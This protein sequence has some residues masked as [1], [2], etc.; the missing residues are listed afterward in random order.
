MNNQPNPAAESS[1]SQTQIPP[2]TIA[3]CCAQCAMIRDHADAYFHGAMYNPYHITLACG[4]A[5]DCHINR[6]VYGYNIFPMGESARRFSGPFAVPVEHVVAF[7]TLPQSLD[8]QQMFTYIPDTPVN[9][10]AQLIPNLRRMNLS[11]R[12]SFDL[13]LIPMKSVAM[14]NVA[15]RKLSQVTNGQLPQTIET[16]QRALEEVEVVAGPLTRQYAGFLLAARQGVDISN[17]PVY[18]ATLPLSQWQ[19]KQLFDAYYWAVLAP[20]SSRR[21]ELIRVV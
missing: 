7:H 18:A 12:D 10:Y 6:M 16:M 17:L 5:L 8:Q 14:L 13:A 15:Y 20:E 3:G 19:R 11:D 4:T 1:S 2:R 9:Q 21:R